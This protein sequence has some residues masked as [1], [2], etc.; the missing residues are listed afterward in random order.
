MSN[1]KHTEIKGVIPALIT[2]F[3][4]NENLDESRIRKLVDF[5]INQKV[6][7]LYLT[8][9]TGEGFLMSL[10]ERKRVVEIVLDE[11]K[12]RIPVIV[13]I[14]AISTRLSI[15]LAKH[16]ENAGAD[17]ISS[18]PPFYWKFDENHIYNY[19]KDISDACTLPMIVYNVPLTG[20][21]GFDFIK[22]L[23]ALENVKG[24]KYTASTH[25]DIYK[26]KELK[27]D[28]MVYSGADEMA[29]SGL[30]NEADGLIGSFYSMMPD[31][32]I[33]LYDYVKEG[34]MDEAQRL[35]K[36]AVAI[37]DASLKCDYYAV[38]KASTKWMGV[39]SGFVRRP[40]VTP[41]DAEIN[42]IKDE[43]RRIKAKYNA[44]DILVLKNL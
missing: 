20:L 32:F 3:D 29:V 42:A 16:A 43:F 4:E 6:N 44:D 11:V 22:R 9:S 25:Q 10:D 12:Q 1:F 26:C 28:F 41:S 24:I 34:K 30:L 17:A 8:G 39:D 40:F 31:L 27:K 14:G 5:L 15:E 35:Q 38:I 19:Y 13:H 2:P 33:R 37:I 21:M 7:G 23:S 36:I 18:V